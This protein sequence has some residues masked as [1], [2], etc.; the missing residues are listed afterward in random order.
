MALEQAKRAIRDDKA[1]FVELAHAATA[2][3]SS[4]D[5]TFEDLLICLKR[6]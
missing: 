4:P 3:A 2:I 1:D 6:N 5:S